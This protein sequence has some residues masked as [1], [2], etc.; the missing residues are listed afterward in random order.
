MTNQEFIES[1]RLEGEEWRPV[2]GYE[3]LYMVSSFGRVV[4]LAKFVKRSYCDNY[5]KSPMLKK[6]QKDA[7]G[8]SMIHLTKDGKSK[9]FLVHRLVGIAFI[10]NPFDYKTIDHLDCNK[11]NNQV[12]NLR[13]C[14]QS[15]NML[16]PITRNRVSSQRK[17]IRPT[18][19]CKTI[20]C[21]KN[22]QP[23]KIYNAIRDAQNDGHSEQCVSR[24]CRGLR[25]TYHGFQWMYL[26]DWITL[27]NQDVKEP[28]SKD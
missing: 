22:N 28:S 12:T 5:L 26:S 18:W 15:Q 1:I 27:I 11:D 25:K 2:V 24:V 3:S 14:T 9:S 17:G 13:W 4:A 19:T 7:N 10:D 20:V 21:I 23:F 16:N 8:Y 6:I